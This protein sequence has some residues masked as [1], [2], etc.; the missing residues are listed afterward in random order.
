MGKEVFP[1]G[2]ER[3]LFYEKERSPGS[4]GS[5]VCATCHTEKKQGIFVCLFPWKV[6]RHAAYRPCLCPPE[7]RRRACGFS[8]SKKIGC[9]VQRNRVRR[10]LKESFRA[11]LPEIEGSVQLIF[12]ARAPIG[13]ASFQEISRDMRYLLKKAGFLPKE[14]AG[15]KK[16][17]ADRVESQP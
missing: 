15:G 9:S 11:L 5:I 2:R 12:I 8:V 17:R 6:L 14:K 10:R 1:K 16:A 3:G 4:K 13:A 7:I